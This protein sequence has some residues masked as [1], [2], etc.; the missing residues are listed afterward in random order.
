MRPQLAAQLP[1]GS[2]HV[3]DQFKG[4]RHVVVT[5]V[6]AK[7]KKKQGAEARLRPEGNTASVVVSHGTAG[8]V[9]QLARASSRARARKRRPSRVGANYQSI[10]LRGLKKG[11]VRFQ[12]VAKKLAGPT[13]ATAQINPVARSSMKVRAAGAQAPAARVRGRRR[14]PRAFLDW[15]T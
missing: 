4:A 12:V 3:A 14:L 1:D 5:A 2:D 8:S 11:K 15:G 13:T 7:K 6:A 9:I 10:N